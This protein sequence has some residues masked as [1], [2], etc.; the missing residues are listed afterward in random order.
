MRYI[1]FSSALILSLELFGA[2]VATALPANGGGIVKANS[3]KDLIQVGGG[4]GRHRHRDAKGNC[5]EM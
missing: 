4:C 5:T 2:S 1:V 3:S